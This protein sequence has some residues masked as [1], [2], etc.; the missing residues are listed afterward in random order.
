MN[1]INIGNQKIGNVF[2]PFIIAEMSGNH[3]Q[4]LEKALEIVDAAADAGAHAIKL[5]TYTADTIT[6]DKKEGE[7]FIS[8]PK[9]L[10]KGESLYDLYKKAYTPWEWHESIF[11]RAK[12]KGIVC[13]SSPF[14]FTA[15]DF[16]ESLNAPAYKIAS[17]ENIDLPLI[18]KVANTGKPIIISTGMA[19]IQEIAEAVDTVRATGNNQL[20]L[21][22]CTSTYPAT[23]DNTNILTIPHMRELFQCEIGLSDHTLGIGVAVASVALGATVIEKHFTLSRAEGGVDSAFSMEPVEM[24]SLVTETERAWQSLGKITYGPTEKER[25][26]MVFRRSLYVVEDMNAGDKITERNVKS[27]RPGYGLPP[28]YL[29]VVVGKKLNRSL[30]MGTPLSWEF[31]E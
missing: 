8:D 15:V 29:D 20:I 17:F 2:K 23:P 30:R 10:W 3:N 22:K 13:F 27:I 31:I 5:Q 11:K 4:S 6:I 28:K 7:F 24:K 12:E 9:S 19:N 18:R 21:L 25:A 26:S 1:K 14:D 16:L